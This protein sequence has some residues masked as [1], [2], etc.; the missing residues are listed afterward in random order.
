MGIAG[1]GFWAVG[2]S[3]SGVNAT[4]Q[5]VM[6]IKAF[7][8][9]DGQTVSWHPLVSMIAEDQSAIRAIAGAVSLAASFAGDAAV[10]LSI[11]VSLAKN[12]ISNQVEA[13]IKNADQ[14]VR[15]TTGSVNL[16]ATEN[17]EDIGISAA[18]SAAAAVAGIAGVIAQWCRGLQQPMSS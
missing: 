18:A 14:E 12:Q 16:K 1:G 9:G 6:S 11:G 7:I 10:A 4:N 17:A 5:I 15:T 13:A 8:D 2:L 3:G